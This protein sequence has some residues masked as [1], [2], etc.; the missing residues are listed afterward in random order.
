[1]Q[2]LT[3][4]YY[5]YARTFENL[6]NQ[7]GKNVGEKPV[8]EGGCQAFFTQ[9]PRLVNHIMP[10]KCACPDNCKDC[11]CQAE[12]DCKEGE[13]CGCG[14]G[15]AAC[16]RLNP[17]AQHIW[18]AEPYRTA[19]IKVAIAFWQ[20][21]LGLTKEFLYWLE[22]HHNA[23]AD[24]RVIVS[25]RKQAFALEAKA[26][27]D[28]KRIPI[29]FGQMHNKYI[30]LDAPMLSYVDMFDPHN[31]SKWYYTRRRRKTVLTGTL[32]LD[33]WGMADSIMVADTVTGTPAKETMWDEYNL[34]FD[35]QFQEA[36]VW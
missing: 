33:N 35:Y 8:S 5:A 32:N 23:G 17:L 28:D 19:S 24:V 25:A 12:E 11:L 36:E 6:W 9:R 30:V 2:G 14:C 21:G 7:Q 27:C 16:R 26:W 31:E 29:R 13:V 3:H 4:I 15:S 1:M 18:R 20:T 34:N 22:R 10:N